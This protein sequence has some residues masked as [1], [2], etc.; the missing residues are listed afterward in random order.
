MIA[1]GAPQGDRPLGGKRR[2]AAH[3]GDQIAAGPP[4]GDRPLGG[5][6]REAAHRGGHSPLHVESSGRGPPLV[7]IHGWAMHS[8]V[9]GSLPSRLARH[10]RV[11]AVD[12][13]GHGFSAPAPTFTVAGVVAALEATFAAETSPLDLVGW[14]LGGQIA[15]AWA[16]ANPQRVARLAL[17]ATT[18]RFVEGDGWVPALSHETLKRFGDE[19][20]VAWKAT[21]LRFLTLQL[22]GSEHAHATLAALRGELFGEPSRRSL[23]EALAALAT[24]DLR[25]DVG[26]VIHPAV[27][28]GGDRDTLVPAAACE[29]LASAMRIGRYAPIAGA[30]H[31]P[32][33]SHPD[34]FVRALCGFLDARHASAPGASR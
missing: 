24:T 31:A 5:K 33:L 12:L 28:I 19:L 18:P 20:T 13:P 17:V 25:A 16:L 30:A 7:L 3:R 2:E 23:S 22:R 10:H 15:L 14:S 27:V 6:R 4:Q 29:W 11:H 8:G 21:V 32:F 26:R 9:W 1:A 34:Q